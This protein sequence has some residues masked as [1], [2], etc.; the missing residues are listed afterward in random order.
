[1]HTT[2]SETA[3][4]ALFT[5]F[6]QTKAMMR[7]QLLLAFLTSFAHGLFL[8]FR[9]AQ[10]QEPLSVQ[11]KHNQDQMSSNSSSLDARARSVEV[12]FTTKDEDEVVRVWLPLGKRVYAGMHHEPYSMRTALH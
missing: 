10:I 3:F 1:M 7:N 12:V 6:A 9:P 8:P 2:S 5:L 11:G 4:D